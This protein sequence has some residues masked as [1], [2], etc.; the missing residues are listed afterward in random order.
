MSNE[1]G[2]FNVEKNSNFDA[3]AAN[4]TPASRIN[5]WSD[6]ELKKMITMGIRPDG[7][8]T[9]PPMGYGFYAAMTENDLDAVVVFLRSLPPLP[10]P[11]CSPVK[12]FGVGWVKPTRFRCRRRAPGHSHHRQMDGIAQ[13]VW[14]PAS[15][16]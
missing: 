2:G 9:L 6:D 8:K 10:D 3:W 12:E 1:F 11:D 15:C 14:R 7:S 13:C 5:D 16:L 4:I